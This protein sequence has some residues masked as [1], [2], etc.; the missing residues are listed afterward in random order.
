MSKKKKKIKSFKVIDVSKYNDEK[1]RELFDAIVE[2][3]KDITLKGI[4]S[5][6]VPDKGQPLLYMNIRPEDAFLQTYRA[7]GLIASMISM[8]EEQDAN[9]DE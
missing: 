3:T 6:V 8:Q 7:T 9:Y 1:T 5:I 4:I 2:E